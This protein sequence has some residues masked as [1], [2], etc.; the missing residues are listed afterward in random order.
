MNGN[1]KRRTAHDWICPNC[2]DT[3]WIQEKCESWPCAV[4][5]GEMVPQDKSDVTPNRELRELDESWLEQAGTSDWN[6]YNEGVHDALK[7]AAK[8]LEEVIADG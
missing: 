7:A 1:N 8:E 2:G 4:C 5:G 6:E 3:I